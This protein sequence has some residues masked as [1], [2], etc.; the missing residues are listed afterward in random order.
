M[1]K[2]DII[3]VTKS[4]RPS[5]EIVLNNIKDKT[6]SPHRIIIIR[7]PSTDDTD[8][9][10]EKN[11]NLYDVLIKKEKQDWFGSNLNIGLEHVLSKDFVV[12]PD[13]YIIHENGWLNKIYKAYKKDNWFGVMP[14]SVPWPTLRHQNRIN[15][16]SE[17]RVFRSTWG[18]N[19]VFRIQ[20]AEKVRKAG[21]FQWI[22]RS[23]NTSKQYEGIGFLH[24]ASKYKQPVGKY[25][26]VR[27]MYFH[28]FS[29][30]RVDGQD[31]HFYKDEL[32]CFK[33]FMDTGEIVMYG[34]SSAE[35]KQH[36]IDKKS[37]FNP[38][39]NRRKK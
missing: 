14:F 17:D 37:R 6:V 23:P 20:N 7:D 34:R 16:H 10:L 19:G 32:K 22:I 29:H 11:K 30:D 18:M 3:I 12:A 5:L 21:G 38:F 35:K 9:Y 13:D 25:L 28:K 8:A 27:V 39:S 24:L 36:F 15:F 33:T 2:I 4:R 26:G 1:E 31:F